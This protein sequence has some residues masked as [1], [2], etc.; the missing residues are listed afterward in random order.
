MKRRD[1][2]YKVGDSTLLSTKNIRLKQPG[3]RKLLPRW[4]GPYKI[5]KEVNPVAFQLNLPKTLRIHDVF[6]ASLLRPYQSDGDF[7][8]Q[9]PLL[10]EGAEEFEVDRIIDHRARTLRKGLTRQYLVKSLDYGPE[11]NTWEPEQNLQNCQQ[12]LRRYWQSVEDRQ[13]TREKVSWGRNS[14]RT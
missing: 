13:G 4:I 6:H 1:V 8:P 9:P 2:E 3:A 10:I 7:H 5:V 14:K 11:H 12:S